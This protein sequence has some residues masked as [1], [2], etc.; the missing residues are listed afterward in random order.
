MHATGRS[1]VL[2]YGCTRYG[3]C[4]APRRCGP[5][6]AARE[7]DG[8]SLSL[9]PC[10]TGAH[11]PGP[12]TGTVHKSERWR[13]LDVVTVVDR[14]GVVRSGLTPFDSERG[15]EAGRRSADSR[16]AAKAAGRASVQAVA[17]EL[18][19][20]AA[21]WERGDLGP[22]AFAAAADL[23]GRVARGD[24]PVRNGSE[25]ADLLRALVDVGRI[26]SGDAQRTVA[27]A[28]LSG[29]ALAARL[30]ELQASSAADT[31]D[32]IGPAT[33]PVTPA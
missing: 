23:I 4:N 28:H 2:R 18:R 25:A 26:E 11:C 17:G 13:T 27:V 20:L 22:L 31:A 30:R 24:V 16:R 12:P 33:S 14:A 19:A 9:R 10:S 7:C 1:K 29:P 3:G 6:R 15:R 5:V 21:T 8:L 32:D